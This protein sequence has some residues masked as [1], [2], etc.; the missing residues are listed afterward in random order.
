MAP[1]SWLHRVAFRFA[2]LLFIALAEVPTPLSMLPLLAEWV[3][4]GWHWLG[5]Q[6]GGALH[7]EVPMHGVSGSGDTLLEWLTALAKVLVAL[8]GTVLWSAVQRKP[9]SH[10][11][12]AD[13]LQLVLRV[14]LI[15]MMFSY[16]ISKVFAGQFP[17]P[18]DYRLAQTFGEASPMGLMWTF[19]GASRPYQIFA[20]LA[21]C[22]GA[23]LLL[24]RRTTLLG[25]LWLIGV[26]GN[27]VLLNF[28]YDVPVKLFSSSLLAMAVMLALPD[29]PRLWRLLISNRP[30]PAAERRW[31]FWANGPWWLARVVL[32]TLLI[33]GN[34]YEAGDALVAEAGAFDAPPAAYEGVFDATSAEAPFRRLGIGAWSVYVTLADGSVQRLAI[35]ADEKKP[36]LTIS[37]RAGEQGHS[38]SLQWKRE[39]DVVTFSGTWNGQPVEVVTRRLDLSKAVLVTRGFHWVNE[40]PFNR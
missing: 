5:L 33:G 15:N 25:A 29:A 17:A 21:E 1:W 32:M 31:Q 35:E 38:A 24:S 9:T 2:F 27:V 12:L 20:G 36:K 11:K 6:L 22:L 8:F 10:H 40:F 3:A 28:F 4:D 7:L 13:V 34:L 37:P 26:L 16:G 19:M 23:L 30:A 39:G 14:V 18:S